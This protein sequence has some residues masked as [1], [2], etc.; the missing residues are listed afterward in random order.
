MAANHLAE[1]GRRFMVVMSSWQSKDAG[2]G[3]PARWFPDK[4]YLT[5]EIHRSFF[6]LFSIDSDDQR[7]RASLLVRFASDEPSPADLAGGRRIAPQGEAAHHLVVHLLPIAVD[8]VLSVLALDQPQVHWD[9]L[10]KVR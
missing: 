2:R 1:K 9:V 5:L 3:S 6:Q 7:I 10:S 8:D 4:S